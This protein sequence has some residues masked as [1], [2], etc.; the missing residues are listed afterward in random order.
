MIAYGSAYCQSFTLPT[1]I[2]DS[3]IWETRKGRS[4]DTLQRIQ[5]AEI[6]ALQNLQMASG[7]VIRIQRQQITLLDSL[8]LSKA[9]E[10]EVNR[11]IHRLEKRGLI[12]DLRR[13]KLVAIGEG[14][15]VVLLV[16]LLL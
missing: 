1:K 10:Q 11:N 3:L 5:M 8:L 15:L 13:L 7:A 6:I 14:V 12:N 4:C 2:L 16:I 9:R